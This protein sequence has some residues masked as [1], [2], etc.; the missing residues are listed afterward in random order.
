MR[1]VCLYWPNGK[2]KRRC[3]FQEGLRVGIDQ[4]WNE[5]GQLVDEGHYEKGK[6][7]GAH[8]RWDEKGTLIEEIVYLDEGKFDLRQWDGKG[9]LRVEAIWSKEAYREK[10]WDR[11]QK[12]WIEKQGYWDGK[13]LVY[14]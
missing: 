9:N 8:R 13:R 3:F 14:S 1:E 12:I 5:E 11:F 10:V 4:M 7:V 2:L 6:P